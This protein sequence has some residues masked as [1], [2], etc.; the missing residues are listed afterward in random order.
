MES[1]VSRIRNDRNADMRSLLR[2]SGLIFNVYSGNQTHDILQ[3][4]H[5]LAKL[6]SMLAPSL[7]PFPVNLKIQLREKSES[8]SDINRILQQN[9]VRN[10]TLRNSQSVH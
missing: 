4:S 3:D 10:S 5:A 8:A 9:L 2:Q 1:L 7:E 6:D